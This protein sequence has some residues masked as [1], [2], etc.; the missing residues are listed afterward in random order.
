MI[1][2]SIQFQ[3]DENGRTENSKPIELKGINLFVG[4]NNSGKTFALEEIGK[5]F[6]YDIDGNERETDEQF[7]HRISVAKFESVKNINIGY[8][9]QV[10]KQ[11]ESAIRKDFWTNE[12]EFKER[13]NKKEKGKIDSDEKRFTAF[14][15]LFN[16]NGINLEKLK[17]NSKINFD[18]FLQSAS[19]KSSYRLLDKPLKSVWKNSGGKSDEFIPTNK[20]SIYL[21]LYLSV[22]KKIYKGN[23]AKKLWEKKCINPSGYLPFI[24]IETTSFSSIKDNQLKFTFSSNVPIEVVEE[25][26]KVRQIIKTKLGFY[27]SIDFNQLSVTYRICNN[28]DYE[29][30]ELHL[31]RESKEYFEDQTPLEEY[32]LGIKSI[33]YLLFK[34]YSSRNSLFLLDEPDVFLHPPYARKLGSILASHSKDFNSQFFIATHNQNLLQGFLESG[35][36]VNVFR[37]SYKNKTPKL[38]KLESNDLQNILK[39]PRLRFSGILESIFSDGVILVEGE[40]DRRVYYQALEL[41]LN[42]HPEER[43]DGLNFVYSDGK[44]NISKMVEMLK[45]LGISTTIILDADALVGEGIIEGIFSRIESVDKQ[46]IKSLKSTFNSQLEKQFNNENQS[47]SKDEYLK[48]NGIG[49]LTKDAKVS[50][51]SLNMIL[52]KNGIFIVPQGDLEKT[53]P[54]LWSECKGNNNEKRKKEWEE[55]A[56]QLLIES[57][58]NNMLPEYPLRTI[59]QEVNRNLRTIINAG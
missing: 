26:K 1:F 3:F 24:S 55:K 49:K 37:F 43:I 18:S 12:D 7:H 57:E 14:Q 38:N 4:A 44:P 48:S 34:I 32:S 59:V 13:K 9:D 2:E 56:I 19:K 54:N 29:K 21:P 45:K 8:S 39:N 22:I 15:R 17:N 27:I 33:I 23:I 40:H 5:F 28:E 42:F 35:E 30:Y 25:F 41:Y 10:F 58:A 47:L 20:N 16:L 6:K 52:K 31:S 36:D 53:I 50:F 46:N 51:D 11:I